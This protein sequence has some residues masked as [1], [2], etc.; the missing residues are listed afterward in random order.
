MSFLGFNCKKCGKP[1]FVMHN[2]PENIMDDKTE[3][4][5]YQR[6]G[7]ELINIPKKIVADIKS[8]CGCNTVKEK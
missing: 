1:F 5:K 2:T 7:Y 6:K 3:I 8:W 4:R